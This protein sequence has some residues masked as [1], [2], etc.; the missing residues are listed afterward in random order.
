MKNLK[1]LFA[2]AFIAISAPAFA[3]FANSGNS[4]SAADT[5]DYNRVGVT[6][7]NWNM[8]PKGGDG[9]GFSG[10]AVDYIH[11]FSVSSDL[12]LFI[13]TGLKFTMGF[14]SEDIEGYD[15]DYSAKMTYGNLSVP[16][17]VAYKF[18]LNDE[19]SIV[20][21]TG[22]NF[23]LN[24][25]GKTK[26]EDESVSWYDEEGGDLKRFQMGWQIGAGLN[27][28]QFYVGLGYEID[29]IKI[30]DKVNTSNFYVGVGYNF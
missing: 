18:A 20:P 19:M 22:I 21:Y 7:N 9:T 2:A 15:D 12:P 6:Y 5:E 14:H 11:G 29:F 17:N 26:V 24:L 25:I 4:S 28:K 27:Y 10:F 8:S 30:A 1:V 13:E 23:K 3:Q 16:V